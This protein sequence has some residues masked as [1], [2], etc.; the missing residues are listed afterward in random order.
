PAQPG[1]GE[2]LHEQVL[3]AR[4]L[5]PDRCEC[6]SQLWLFSLELFGPFSLHLE[7][8]YHE[9]VSVC[10]VCVCV[11]VCTCVCVCVCVRVVCENAEF[12]VFAVKVKIMF[13]GQGVRV[14]ACV[15]RLL[16][17][18]VCLVLK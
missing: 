10:H 13:M 6:C 7:K 5:H 2:R 8:V 1:C 3:S 18:C 9:V 17:E 16:R 11:C 15:E 12:G 4:H 14:Y